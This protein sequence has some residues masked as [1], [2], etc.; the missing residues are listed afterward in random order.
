MFHVKHH[1]SGRFAGRPTPRGKRSGSAG[2]CGRRRS[3][4]PTLHRLR[5]PEAQLGQPGGGQRSPA[6][7]G[8]S[9]TTRTP[10]TATRPGRDLGRDRRARRSSG[11]SPASK[12]SRYWARST[13]AARPAPRRPRPGRRDPARNRGP[14][15][16]SP[17]GGCCRR[18]S[19]EPRSSA[20][21]GPGP[22]TPPPVP[23]SAKSP[24]AVRARPRPRPRSPRRGGGG[25]RPGPGRGIRPSRARFQDLERSAHPGSPALMPRPA[26]PR[27]TPGRPP[28][29]GAAL[30]PPRSCRPRR[31]RRRRRARPCGRRRPSAPWPAPRRSL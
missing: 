19:L 18:R 10:P 23:R 1:H 16:A 8:G 5:R 4:P 9:L 26:T 31:C 25:S 3:A 2:P 22:G 29:G 6:G 30:R 28:P 7:S 21:P 12:C 15:R 24:V 14:A 11:R 20:G 13:D 17:G 27:L